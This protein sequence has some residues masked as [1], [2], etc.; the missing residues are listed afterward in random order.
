MKPKIGIDGLSR[1][2]KLNVYLGALREQQLGLGK[3]L[4]LEQAQAML[5]VGKGIVS[6][7]QKEIIEQEK[8]AAQ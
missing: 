3:E 8:A 7:L 6:V 4:S 2:L 5:E 1:R